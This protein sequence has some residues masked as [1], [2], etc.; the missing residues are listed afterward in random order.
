MECKNKH[1][2]HFHRQWIITGDK[3]WIVYNNV[4]RKRSWSKHDEPAQTI[5]K[6]ELHQKR[7]CCQFGGITKVLC[8]LSCFQTTERSTQMF[9]AKNVWNWRKQSKR[10]GQ[11]WQIAKEYEASHI[12]SNTY[13]TIRAWLG[14][15]VASPIQPRPCSIGLSF[16]SKFIKLLK[17]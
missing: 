2:R 3:K 1:F 9:T 4:N 12:F 15:D 5:S 14:S 17:W 8:I 11:N 13:E 7:L 6:A 16:T 10:K